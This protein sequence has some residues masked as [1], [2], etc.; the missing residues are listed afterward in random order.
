MSAVNY[1]SIHRKRNHLFQSDVA[2]LLDFDET[3]SV[4]RC[5]KGDRKPSVEI[6]LFYHLVFEA[7][8]TEL[9]RQD[10]LDLLNKLRCRIPLLIDAIS[11][12]PVTRR[13]YQRVTFLKQVLSKLN[14]DRY[15]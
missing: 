4:S 6:L 14:D 1:L 9:Y 13:N 5:E 12:K 3:S 15:A 11:S 10:Q 8:P 7:P 2:F